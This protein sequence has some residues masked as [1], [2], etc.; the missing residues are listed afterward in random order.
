MSQT[1]LP[2]YVK[3]LAFLPTR[4]QELDIA[5]EQMLDWCLRKLGYKTHPHNWDDFMYCINQGIDNWMH[6]PEKGRINFEVKNFKLK[7]SRLSIPKTQTEVLDIFLPHINKGEICILLVARAVLPGSG[8]F[9][10]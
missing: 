1:T 10:H 4:Y 3:P 7:T 2:C 6:H 8:L 9:R 5:G